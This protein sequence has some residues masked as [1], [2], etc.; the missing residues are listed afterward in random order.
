MSY[1]FFNETNLHMSLKTSTSKANEFKSNLFLKGKLKLH[2]T[3][4]MEIK[5]LKWKIKRINFF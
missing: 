1:L 2:I 4:T 5:Q 3:K